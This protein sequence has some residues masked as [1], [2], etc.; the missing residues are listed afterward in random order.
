MN[1]YLDTSALIKLYVDEPGSL[2]VRRSTGEAHLVAT[3]EIAYVELRAALARRRREGYITPRDYRQAITDIHADWL[4]YFVIEVGSTIVRQ[5]GEIAERY[6]LRAYD[7]VHLA[8][9]LSLHRGTGKAAFFG[10]WDANLSA[11]AVKA[12]MKPLAL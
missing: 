6:S 9:A 2:V 1:L 8:S 7:A 12:G 5:A 10:C 3:A 11:A 4:T